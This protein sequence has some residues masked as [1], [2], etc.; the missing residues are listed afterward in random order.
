MFSSS[1]KTIHV[2]KIDHACE[3]NRSIIGLHEGAFTNINRSEKVFTLVYIY[4]SSHSSVHIQIAFDLNRSHS[5]VN[6]KKIFLCPRQKSNLH[7]T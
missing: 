3:Q 2:N 7:V 1:L 4:L 6:Y 5:S